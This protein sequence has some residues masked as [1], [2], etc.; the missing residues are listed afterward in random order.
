[1]INPEY[2]E[3]Q[4]YDSQ[5]Q[6]ISKIFRSNQYVACLKVKQNPQHVYNPNGSDAVSKRI[7]KELQR[8]ERI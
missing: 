5:T 2:D 7:N 4:L 6:F 1:M 3:A 8:V